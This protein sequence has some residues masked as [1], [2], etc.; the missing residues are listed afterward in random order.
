MS[1]A[2]VDGSVILDYPAIARGLLRIYPRDAVSEVI[3]S[4]P[5]LPQSSVQVDPQDESSF[6]VR[7][8]ADGSGCGIDGVPLQN[9]RVAAALRAEMPR[10]ATRI[11]AIDTRAGA[12]AELPWGVSAEQIDE[13]WRP[14]GEF[15]EHA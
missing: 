13:G 10:E 7:L 3:T 1:I 9:A 2:S 6:S 14:V 15:G 11:V 8:D 12:F 5:P 4:P